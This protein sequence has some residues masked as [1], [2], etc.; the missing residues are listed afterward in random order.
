[1]KTYIIEAKVT[2]MSSISH[3]GGEQNGIVTHLRREK[4][5]QP[6]GKIEEVPVI[7]G[8]S[9]RGKM[10]DISALDVLTKEDYTKIKVDLESHLL[11]F[12]GGALES[13]GADKKLNLEKVRKMRNDMP[14]LSILGC[15]I[16]NIIL[17]G[18]LQVG[19]MYPICKEMIH[20]IPENF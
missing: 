13:V 17:P 2:L 12:S 11:L 19:K 5:V 1:M 16:G 7:S 3:N 15:S 9:S 4:F 8:N 10:R 18:K 20:L 14:A 6:K